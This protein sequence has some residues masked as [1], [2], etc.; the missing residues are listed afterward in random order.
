MQI[1]KRPVGEHRRPIQAKGL[2]EF[3]SHELIRIAVRAASRRLLLRLQPLQHVVSQR[4]SMQLLGK[5][6]KR[7]HDR[8]DAAAYEKADGF[9]A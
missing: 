5:G 8:N 7:H 4:C 3:V 2:R 1:G 9:V 6:R